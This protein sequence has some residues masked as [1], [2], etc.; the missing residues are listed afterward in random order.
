M[1]QG[2]KEHKIVSTKLDEGQ[3]CEAAAKTQQILAVIQ[4]TFFWGKMGKFV[5]TT[6]KVKFEVI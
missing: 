3:K 5:T 2:R 1:A 6:R 4:R